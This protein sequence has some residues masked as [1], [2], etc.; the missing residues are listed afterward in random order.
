MAKDANGNLMANPQKG[1]RPSTLEKYE[2]LK[3]LIE[4]NPDIPISH[5]A[6]R[7]KLAAWIYREV[8]K[9]KEGK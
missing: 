1:F 8:K 5:L 2:K 9:M 4:A 3:K 6:S 7:V